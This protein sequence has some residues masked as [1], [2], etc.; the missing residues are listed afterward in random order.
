MGVPVEVP[1]EAP[2]GPVRL[3]HRA[4]LTVSSKVRLARQMQYLK[5]PLSPNSNGKSQFLCSCLMLARMYT[6]THE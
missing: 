6:L 1:A 2:V 4:F 3:R 5:I